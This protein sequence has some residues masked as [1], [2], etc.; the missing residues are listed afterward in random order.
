MSKASRMK[1]VISNTIFII[2]ILFMSFVAIFSSNSNNY[3][4]IRKIWGYA[5]CN[6]LTGSMEPTIKQGSIILIKETDDIEN[7]DIITIKTEDTESIV[8][9]RVVKIN[10]EGKDLYFTTRGDANNTDDSFK[11]KPSMVEGKVIFSIPYLGSIISFL[12]RNIFIV[13]LVVIG[14]YF[15]FSGLKKTIKN[16]GE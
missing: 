5:V 13:I 9:H 4:S 10:G 1:K 12:Q 3:K 8:T 7:G 14:L 2:V 11:V 6:V 15:I 16:E